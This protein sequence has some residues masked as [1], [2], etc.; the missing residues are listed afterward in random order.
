MYKIP[1][2]YYF[3]I[4]HVRPRFKGDIENVLLFVA[5]EIS[6]IPEQP[7]K[8]FADELNN[9]IRRYPGNAIREIKTINN[10]RTEISSL[11]GYYIVDNGITKPG[12]RALD[13]AEKE[14]FRRSSLPLPK[15]PPSFRP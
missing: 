5:T 9:A 10:W 3:R 11:F 1:E 12:Q 8:D 6:K 14:D 4:H 2:E 7:E 13:L 15:P